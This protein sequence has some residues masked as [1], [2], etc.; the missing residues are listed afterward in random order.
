MEVAGIGYLR[1]IYRYKM[2]RKTGII[3]LLIFV[4][5]AVYA[6]DNLPSYDRQKLR[7]GFSIGFNSSNLRMVNRPGYSIPDSVLTIT[8]NAGPG[9]NIGVVSNGLGIGTQHQSLDK[10]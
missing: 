8:P 5:T 4:T 6:Q 7:F 1:H 9:F 2:M 3:C 10:I